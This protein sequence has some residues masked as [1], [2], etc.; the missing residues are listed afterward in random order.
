MCIQLDPNETTPNSR[1]DKRDL[2]K[3]PAPHKHR[4]RAK[5]PSQPQAGFCTRLP[6]TRVLCLQGK[7]RTKC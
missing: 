6:S 7:L 5:E 2:T 4:R 3:R 1:R